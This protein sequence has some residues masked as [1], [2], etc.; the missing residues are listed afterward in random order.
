L[1]VYSLLNIFPFKFTPSIS[2]SSLVFFRNLAHILSSASPPFRSFSR[3]PSTSGTAWLVPGL[4]DLR[5]SHAVAIDVKFITTNTRKVCHVAQTHTH[6][7]IVAQTCPLFTPPIR[8]SPGT[9]RTRARTRTRLFRFRASLLLFDF[10]C[11]F[12]EQQRSGDSCVVCDC[13]CFCCLPDELW[14]ADPGKARIALLLVG[15]LPRTQAAAGDP[16]RW[17]EHIN[18]ILFKLRYIYAPCSL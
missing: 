2:K 7:F 17:R 11:E 3:S 14:P 12:A 15:N 5:W 6:A 13:V 16:F 10:W 1:A 18:A 8:I 9:T 4:S